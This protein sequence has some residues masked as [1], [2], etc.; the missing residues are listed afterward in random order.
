MTQ[1]PS[2]DSAYGVWTLS[3]IRNAR[4]GDNWPEKVIPSIGGTITEI[5]EGGIDYRVHTFT[6]SG[7]FQASSSGNNVEYLVVAG[8]GGGGA[9]MGGGGGAGGFLS[10][11]NLAL[12]G[13]QSY[14]V[15]V[16]NGGANGG[17]YVGDNGDNGGNSSFAGFLWRFWDIWAR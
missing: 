8:G 15:I 12:N 16:G 4:R 6:S 14:S 9:A 11:S 1:F 7:T 3:E 17:S 5:T 2:T 10:G 13:S